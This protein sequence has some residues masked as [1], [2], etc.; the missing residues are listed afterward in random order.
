MNIEGLFLF[1]YKIYDLI[2]LQWQSQLLKCVVDF[3]VL[4]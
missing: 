2:Y 1:H 4:K 3:R